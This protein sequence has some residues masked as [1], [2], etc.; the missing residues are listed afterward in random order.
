MPPEFFVFPGEHVAK[1]GEEHRDVTRW[2]NTALDKL[3]PGVVHDE[4][5]QALSSHSIR[6]GAASTFHFFLGD[7]CLLDIKIWINWKMDAA[8][9][10]MHYIKTHGWTKEGEMEAARYFY[11]HAAVRRGGDA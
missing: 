5:R 3:G 10:Q 6:E 1:P 4:E 8:T 2:L 7:G 11:K 9:P